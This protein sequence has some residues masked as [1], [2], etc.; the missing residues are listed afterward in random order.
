MTAPVLAAAAAVCRVPD[1][2]PIVDRLARLP[3]DELARGAQYASATAVALYQGSRSAQTAASATSAAWSSG[4]T[5]VTAIGQTA[6]AA[7]ASRAAMDTLSG[8]LG[9]ARATMAQLQFQARA[10]V[11]ESESALLAKGFDPS[12]GRADAPVTQLPFPLSSP[13]GTTIDGTPA[14][15]LPLVSAAH[16]RL[17]G[18]EA[19]LESALQELVTVLRV[20][21]R[22]MLQRLPAL[23]PATSTAVM[24]SRPGDPAGSTSS[25]AAPTDT[26]ARPDAATASEADAQA[27]ARL[28]TDLEST[29]ETTRDRA[30]SVH[31][32]LADAEKSGQPV[33]LLA[34]TSATETDQGTAAIGIGDLGSADT[35]TTMVPG[36]QNS[37]DDMFGAL[38][39]A[40]RLQAETHRRSPGENTAV[41]AWFGYDIPATNGYTPDR[42]GNTV[43]AADD[44]AAVAG[45]QTLTADITR[46]RRYAPDTA[47]QVVIGHSMGSVVVSA[48]AAQGAVIDDVILLGSPGAS[49]N[50]DSVHDYPNVPAGHTWVLALD[51]FITRPEIDIG[52]GAVDAVLKLS[53]LVSLDPRATLALA[54]QMVTDPPGSQFG[55][56]PAAADFGASTIDARS[57]RPEHSLG[58]WFGRTS[59]VPAPLH[60]SGAMAANEI[61]DFFNHPQGNYLSGSALTAIADITAGHVS[62]VPT[63]PG[64]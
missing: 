9:G 42:P 38:S 8:A 18:L 55:P 57:S 21:P 23:P 17:R 26:A 29:D 53:Q 5:A 10:V 12:T 31:A 51:D 63:K 54:A 11:T 62:D 25:G 28:A 49:R 16:D 35:V 50:A 45:A 27:R 4:R 58:Q 14:L 2:T 47:R 60:L 7:M 59:F 40:A 46:F 34:Y 48:A 41:V 37:P 61:D 6:M 44:R 1:P 52:A 39:E 24:A 20:D 19:R 22:D 15:L 13:S 33:Q 30:A 3:I 64:R 32:A 43:A 36:V 56:D